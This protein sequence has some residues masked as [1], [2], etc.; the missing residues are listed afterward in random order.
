VKSLLVLALPLAIGSPAFTPVQDDLLAVPGSLSNAWADFD[1]DGDPD[2]AVTAKSGAILLYRN[3]GGT[4]VS[5]GAALGLPTAGPEFR[6]ISWGDF[7]GD[8]RMDLFAGSSLRDKPS[9]LFRNTG[10]GFSDVAAAVGLA[11]PGRVSRQANWIDYDNDGDVDLYATDRAGP[12]RLYRNDGGRFAFAETGPTVAASTVGACWLDYDRDGDLDLFLANQSGKAD[13]LFRN[14][15]TGF[16]DVAPALGIHSPGR[17]PREGGV[18]CA[19]GDYDGDGNFDIFVPSYGRNA[20]WKGDGK[21][22]FTDAAGS[23]GLGV[24]N[25]AVGAAWGDYDNDGDPDLSVMSYDGEPGKQVPRNALFR[26]DAGRF[27]NVIANDSPLNRGDH[28]VAWVDYDRDGDLDLSITKGYT[29]IG[30]HYL[31]RNDLPRAAARRSLSVLVVDA[32]GRFTQAGAEVRI[33]DKRN[34]LLGSAQVSTGGGY[35]AQGALPVHF[36]VGIASRVNVEVTFMSTRGRE[37]Q[38][39]RGVDLARYRRAPLIVRRGP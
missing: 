2:M 18:G 17:S 39:V 27:V 8:G 19:I 28:G 31:F 35:G 6:A 32:N 15:G 36:G 38:T 7:D 21:G 34:E 13:A 5:V 1:N 29:D 10:A 4:L 37:V 9:A 16:T 26:N 30:G 3:D 23:T 25:Y 14:D 33:Y 22:G 11:I 12:N 24:Q 20:L